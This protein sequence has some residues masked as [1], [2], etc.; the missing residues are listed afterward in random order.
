MTPSISLDAGTQLSNIAHSSNEGEPST[1]LLPTS[2]LL[3]PPAQSVVISITPLHSRLLDAP[4]SIRL[5]VLDCLD[6][7]TAYRCLNTCR[8]MHA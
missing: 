8:A 6:D 3:S 5:L 7:K 2:S 1:S 4:S